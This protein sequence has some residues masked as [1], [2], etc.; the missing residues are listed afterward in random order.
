VTARSEGSVPARETAGGIVVALRLTP[1]AGRDEVTGLEIGADGLAFLMARVR[2]LPEKGKA[3]AALAALIADWLA[4]PKSTCAVV[5]GGKSRPCPLKDRVGE[6]S[7]SLLPTIF[8]V[9]YTGTNCLPLCTAMV[10]P[11]KSGVII[12]ALDHVLMTVFL[13]DSTFCWIF[14]SRLSWTKGPFLSERAISYA[15]ISFYVL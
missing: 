15:F 2:A 14:F 1:K 9:I 7:P 5:S 13:P 12:E 8:S 11:T 10:C 3:N 4:L 6:N